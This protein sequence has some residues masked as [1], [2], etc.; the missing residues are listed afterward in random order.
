MNVRERER[1]GRALGPGEG[2]G[3]RGGGSFAGQSCRCRGIAGNEN[4]QPPGMLKW[5]LITSSIR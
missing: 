2:E 3:G 1:D 5:E 4:G